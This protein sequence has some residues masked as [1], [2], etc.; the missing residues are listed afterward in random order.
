M[1]IF[2]SYRRADSE[3][4]VGPMY[5][6]LIKQF[7]KDRVFRDLDSLPIGKPF[8]QAL[9]KAVAEA[10]VALIVIGP[11][12]ASIADPEGRRRL[13]NPA[14]F[15]RLEV[16]KALAAGFPVV[17][18]LVNRATMPN[19]DDLP[20]SLR[21]L[22]FLTG[23]QVRPDPDFHRDMDSLIDKLSA[24]LDVKGTKSART[25][26]P[27]QPDLPITI[28]A[29]LYS[30][31]ERPSHQ[32]RREFAETLEDELSRAGFHRVQTNGI[33]SNE[34]RS[35]L[36]YWEVSSPVVERIK[37]VA[38]GL[39]TPRGVKLFTRQFVERPTE[40]DGGPLVWIEFGS[41]FNSAVGGTE[42]ETSRGSASVLGGDE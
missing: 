18:V 32:C 41:E 12:W 38:E 28:F 22:I 13:D 16:E 35:Y 30:W 7:R 21:P 19:V 36:R 6:R 17:P 10:D 26:Q 37:A 4:I 5:D 40:K 42:A 23:S 14:D 3:L 8:P 15:V 31:K 11:T 24:L 27:E 2:L 1:D 39:L 20:E 9:E 34:A 29:E 25:P 33:G